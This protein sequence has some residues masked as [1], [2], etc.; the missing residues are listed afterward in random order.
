M[1]SSTDHTSEILTVLVWQNSDN[2]DSRPNDSKLF[3][4]SFSFQ[5]VLESV[6]RSRRTVSTVHSGM[7]GPGDL[8]LN[9]AI[10][11]KSEYA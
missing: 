4:S 3:R 7:A 10:L 1:T 2:T 9:H 6:D 5:S 11:A 8:N